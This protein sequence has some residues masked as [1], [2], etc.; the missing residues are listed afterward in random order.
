MSGSWSITLHWW[1]HTVKMSIQISVAEGSLKIWQPALATI[2]GRIYWLCSSSHPW[3]NYT[4]WQN[5]TSPQ[6]TNAVLCINL[7]YA[8]IQAVLNSLREGVTFPLDALWHHLEADNA[9]IMLRF[10]LY[11]LFVVIQ[12]EGQV[13]VQI[14]LQGKKKTCSLSKCFR[15]TEIPQ[16]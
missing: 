11:L 16:T 13:V 2:L 4:I 10:L 5:P 8:C 1:I 3:I 7:Y 15:A 6:T 12:N 14:V 9:V